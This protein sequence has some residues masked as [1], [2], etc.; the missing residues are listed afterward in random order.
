MLFNEAVGVGFR[1]RDLGVRKASLFETRL[2]AISP[3]SLV[4]NFC[5]LCRIDLQR[6][7]S[8]LK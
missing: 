3:A 7:R 2:V 8:A 1:L 5:A 4:L 6:L